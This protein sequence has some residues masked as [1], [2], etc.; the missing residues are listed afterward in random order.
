MLDL[1]FSN[2]ATRP[3]DSSDQHL[4]NCSTALGGG[5]LGSFG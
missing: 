3:G 2:E 5:Y 4:G 1:A